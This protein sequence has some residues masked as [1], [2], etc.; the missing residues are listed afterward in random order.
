MRITRN[1]RAVARR[2][3][4]DWLWFWIGTH[5]EFDRLFHK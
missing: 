4:D 1:Y 5:N 2:Y 3:S